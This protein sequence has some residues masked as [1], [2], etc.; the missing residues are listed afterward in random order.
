MDSIL[1]TVVIIFHSFFLLS[2]PE[3]VSN[4]VKESR[5]LIIKKNT[6][7][8]FFHVCCIT[9]KNKLR[10]HCNITIIMNVTLFKAHTQVTQ[11]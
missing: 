9:V 6:F 8:V 7:P 11:N 4:E 3:K 10:M 1:F 5:F 2:F